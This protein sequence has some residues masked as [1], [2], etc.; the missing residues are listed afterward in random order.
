MTELSLYTKACQISITV[1]KKYKVDLFNVYQEAENEKKSSKKFEET[2][3]FLL[4][5]YPFIPELTTK[6]Q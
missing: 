3:S 5:L 6:I 1:R 2:Q 4:E